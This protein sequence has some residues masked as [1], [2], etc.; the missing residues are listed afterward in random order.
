LADLRELRA[1]VAVA[2]ELSFTRAAERLNLSQQTVS[3]TVR[4]LERELGVELLERTTREVRVTDA[5]RALLAE[6][7]EALLLADAAFEA[8]R[9]VGTGEAGTLRVGVTPAIGPED[10]HDLVRALRPGHPELSVSLRE[11]RPGEFRRAL[12]AHEVDVVLNRATGGEDADIHAAAL[13][14]SRMNVYVKADHRLA[15]QG[16]ASLGDFDGER[17]L[18]P[19]APGTPYTDLVVRRFAEAGAAVT[20]VETKVT[21]GS[22]QLTELDRR[23]AIAAMPVATPSP[24]GVVVLEVDGF[25]LPFQLLWAAGRPPVW[26]ERIRAALGATDE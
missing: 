10:R 5:G 18:T 8:A 22:V 26:V 12:G 19:S 21:G 9:A 6:G 1:L 20:P 4:G 24:P 13:R 23:D 16:H 25:T 2:E 15:A 3:E 14:P 11:L 17:I 7:R